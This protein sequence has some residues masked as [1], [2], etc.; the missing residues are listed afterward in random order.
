MNGG[1]VYDNNLY[2]LCF[3]QLRSCIGGC[4]NPFDGRGAQFFGG[5]VPVDILGFAPEVGFKIGLAALEALVGDQPSVL[6][7]IRDIKSG[8]S[9]AGQ[10][11][12]DRARETKAAIDAANMLSDQ[13]EKDQILSKE[14]PHYTDMLEKAGHLFTKAAGIEKGPQRVKALCAY[15]ICL[16]KQGK[17]RAADDEVKRAKSE[18][19]KLKVECEGKREARFGVVWP[20]VFVAVGVCLTALSLWWLCIVPILLIV[21]AI[22]V[23]GE[24]VELRKRKAE[25]Y[26]L[27]DLSAHI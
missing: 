21:R 10:D 23:E 2:H 4:P 1:F 18:L 3:R 9:Q 22:L 16:R 8:A 12:V 27:R 7:D 19:V 14:L 17:D 20:G 26:E 5:A 24:N 11:F 25:I 6:K 13:F 15:A